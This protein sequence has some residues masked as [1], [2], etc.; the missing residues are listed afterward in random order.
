MSV[1]ENERKLILK[2]YRSLDSSA[3]YSAV[4]NLWRVLRPKRISRAK[5]VR[6]LE[7]D[8]TA[9]LHKPRRYRFKRLKT[10]PAG[11]YTDASMDLMFMPELEHWNNGMR[12]VLVLVEGL[13]RRIFTQ[14]LRT[15][16][17]EDVIEAL[18]KI[19]EEADYLFWSVFSD[20]GKEFKNQ[21][22]KEF[23][24]SLQI[25]QKLA[26]NAE[27][28]AALAERAIRTL[29]QR[30]YKYMSEK[31][32]YRWIDALHPL[33][34]AINRSPNRT[35]GFRPLDVNIANWKNVWDRLY[36]NDLNTKPSKLKVGD[37]VRISK[38]KTQFSKGYHPAWTD[39][40][41]QISKKIPT[42]PTTFRLEDYHNNEPSGRFYAHELSKTTMDTTWRIERVLKTRT[43]RGRR[44]LFVE[45]KNHPASDNCWINESDL[46]D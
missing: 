26:H 5:I 44:Q 11:F 29:K 19:F 43:R 37:H 7:E 21:K 45:W 10:K 16:K 17:P 2:A 25:T 22:V 31:N 46:T 39:E 14:P 24:S 1:D 27:T 30:L 34:L 18:K 20:L 23:L 38:A 40:V 4:D 33:T 6:V 15:K 12:Y 28:K 9:S 41:F 35:L 8:R 36:A 42:N 3:A 13:S 32:T